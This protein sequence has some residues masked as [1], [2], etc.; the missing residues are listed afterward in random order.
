M[1]VQLAE[2]KN[3]MSEYVRAV[4]TGSTFEI[5]VRGVPVALLTPIAKPA[6][7]AGFQSRVLSLMANPNAPK[8]DVKAALQEGRK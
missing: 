5:T 7:K 4:Q 8:L 1:Q 3:K 6:S 2:I